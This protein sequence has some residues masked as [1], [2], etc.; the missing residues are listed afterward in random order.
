VQ[1]IQRL[2]AANVLVLILLIGLSPVYQDFFLDRRDRYRGASFA[3][4]VG[5]LE[6]DRQVVRDF[7]W[8]RWF[9]DPYR[10]MG[11]PRLQDLGMRPL[12]PPQLLLVRFLPAQTA[13]HWNHVLHVLIKVAG[14][15]LLCAALGWPFWVVVFASAGAM[16]AEGSLVQFGDTTMLLSAAWLPLQLWLTLQAAK[17]PGFSWWD[18]AWSVV[19]A[20]RV[21]SFHPQYGAYY[22]VLVVLFMLRVE[23]GRLLV[24]LPTL[25]LRYAAAGLLLA[26]ALVPGY[27][28]YLESGR[29][30]IIEFD[31]WHL[32]RA[33]LWWNYGLQWRDFLTAAFTPWLAWLAIGGGLLVGRLSGTILW[34]V[35]AAYMLFGLFHAVP[36][37]ALPM[38]LTG[39]ALFPFRIPQRVF[40]PFMWL[41]ILLIA[42][43]VAREL[44]ARRRLVLGGLLLVAFGAC[45][46]QTQHDPR[47]AYVMPPWSRALPHRLA[48][49]IRGAEP[50]HVAVLTG[51][52]AMSDT[53]EPILNSNHGDFLRIPAAHFTG[54]LPNYHFN[55]MAYRVPGLLLLPRG[56]TQLDE[57]DA[58]VDIYAELGIGWVIWDGEG[59]P[60]HPRLEPA[61]EEAGFRLFRIRDARPIVYVL[62]SVRVVANPGRP[63]GVAALVYGMPALGP[64]CYGC[65]EP[66]RWSPVDQVRL[67]VAW[68][69]GDV[70]VT[71]EA[72]EGTFV[73]LNEARS[74]GWSARIDGRSATIYPINEAFQGVLV[75]P[76]R[77]VIHWQ[78]ASPG[79]A[80]GVVLGGLGVAVLL[81][82][83]WWLGRQ[84]RD[85]RA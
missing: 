52:E 51:P 18:A 9:W 15:V 70:R 19:L 43:L 37:L 49:T 57:W 77:H 39:K 12:Y 11:M 22:E 35:L 46:W 23:W 74:I 6:Y 30:R 64:F 79:F 63:A 68:E 41:G 53:H 59:D 32:R 82:A 58:V 29:R 73:V 38:W 20:M 13:W 76:G 72:R 25:A 47:E 50:T 10:S 61:G 81:V 34:P 75:P 26:P 67:S 28:H 85:P 60:V 66:A 2:V 17:R 7:T 80:F 42:E 14:L 33:Y 24:R 45:A 62:D 27:F 8:G 78:F 54:Q 3:A 4:H 44:R 71:S 56:P 83:P 65:P 31:D 55:R 84:P 5:P 36:Y 21:L 16:L 69:P 48:A 1:R 40:E